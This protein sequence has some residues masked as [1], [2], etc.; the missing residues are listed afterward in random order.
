MLGVPSKAEPEQHWLPHRI[1]EKIVL[2]SWE[3][4]GGNVL[5]NLCV[6]CETISAFCARI[7]SRTLVL[8]GRVR[9]RACTP[10]SQCVRESGISRRDMFL[11]LYE[12]NFRRE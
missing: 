9:G 12:T 7:T 11:K 1:L 3:Q 2:L 4:F 5:Q 6:L 8:P 10:P